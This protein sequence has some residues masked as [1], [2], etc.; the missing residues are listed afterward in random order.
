MKCANCGNELSENT[1]FCKYCG[2]SAAMGKQQVRKKRKSCF[3]T[4]MGCCVCILFIIVTGVIAWRVYEKYIE[5]NEDRNARREVYR[6]QNDYKQEEK[7][8]QEE[9]EA[10]AIEESESYQEEIE[11]NE[12]D[13][14]LQSEKI[15]NI[16][17]DKITKVTASSAL[18]EYDMTHSPERIVDGNLSTAWVEGVTGQGKGEY[19]TFEFNNNYAVNGFVINAGFQQSEELYQKNSRPAQ[20]KVTFA[21]ETSTIY[22]LEEINGEQDIRLEKPVIS[23][24]ITFSIMAVYPGTKYEDTVISEIV[25]Y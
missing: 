25:L 13:E 22:Y 21:D 11:N 3:R 20:L 5:M 9:S 15:A 8:L 6:V 23:N 1:K 18:S 14:L 10:D 4:L 16:S 24:N 12:E 19:I 7:E 17:M 2:T